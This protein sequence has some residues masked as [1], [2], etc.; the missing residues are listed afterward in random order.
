MTRE[1]QLEFCNSCLNRS[2]DLNEDIICK[3]TNRIADFSD[4]CLNFQKDELASQDQI[5]GEEEYNINNKFTNDLLFK[6][7]SFQD[8]NF[9]IAGGTLVSIICAFLWAFI[10]L[11]TKYQVG[12]MALGV[13]LIVGLGV[14]YFGAG[15][16]KRFGYAG[17]LLSLLGCLLGNFLSQVGFAADEYNQG[18]FETLTYLKLSDIPII[19]KESFQPMDL[20]F[21]GL[22]AYEGY[23]FSFRSIPES[24]DEEEDF[25][26]PFAKFRLPLTIVSLIVIT[27]LVYNVSQGATGFKTFFY[28]S[29]N[30]LSEGEFVNGIPDGKW[31]Y[32]YENGTVQLIANFNNGIEE[33]K[34]QWF[35]DDNSLIR[36][37]SFKNG[38]EHGT[39]TQYYANNNISDSGSY[40]LGRQHGDWIYF[41][42]DGKIRQRGKLIRDMK[43]G[44]WE[45]LDNN[46]KLISSGE[47]KENE[48]S[49]IWNFWY[50]TGKQISQMQFLPENKSKILAA[51][52][53]KNRQI[54][55]DGNGLFVSFHPNGVNSE[56]GKVINGDRV[57][58]WQ[59]FYSNH[60]LKQ[61][62]E[63]KNGDYFIN[64]FWDSEG[65]QSVKNGTGYFNSSYEENDF[66][67]SGNY[68]DGLK[69][70]IWKT[71]FQQPNKIISENYYFDGK[72]S[73]LSK[74]YYE[75]GNLYTEGSHHNNKQDGEWNWYYENGSIQSSVNFSQGKKIGVQKFFGSNGV[76]VKEEIYKN[77]IFI[78]EQIINSH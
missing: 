41:Y 71:Y 29:G 27:V 7:R 24:I 59:S 50:T 3:L 18:F 67:E 64:N 47:F 70:G 20:I 22:A 65:N 1:E 5:S 32:F 16:D 39:W 34:W 76:L 57:G 62:G 10:T 23:K 61:E 2:M 36:E 55:K 46:G 31:K 8:F 11:K 52:D 9:A 30:K 63:Y 73:G 28:E 13:G 38:L 78:K 53:N 56:K 74:F 42:E 49:G 4:Q 40:Y 14:R 54:V 75:S 21:Y 33:G 58:L 48:Y 44:I 35:S 26:P 69:T 19:I 6:L 60:S 68:S 12:Y 72:L 43:E 45:F 77:G 17:L 66:F 51:W 15:I 37:G 25:T